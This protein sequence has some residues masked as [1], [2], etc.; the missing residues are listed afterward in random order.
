MCGRFRVARKKEILEEAFDAECGVSDVEWAPG[1]V[2]RYNVAPGQEIAVVRQ[3][4]ARPLR[5]LSPML[6]G[7]I[8]SWADGPAAGYKMI[9]LRSET[10]ATRPAFRELLRS[11]RC[12]IPSDGFYEWKREGK[13][14]L[15]FCFA[16]AG[17]AMFAFAGLWERWK[18]PLGQMVESCTILTTAPNEL[19]QEIHDRMPVMLA[20]GAY[21]LWL[22]P[23]V[24][25]VKDLQPLLKP[26]PA[27]AMRRYRVSQRVNQVKNDD[28]ECATE[29][30]A[31]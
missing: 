18:N 21:D 3:D 19:V 14:K 5:R 8:P 28:P 9:N 4:P 13:E 15:P 12:L 17:D 10:V 2:P 16:L 31:A 27:E 23:G 22:D 30:E 24:T 6:W 1:Y 7:L 29:I 11:R 20:P 26:Y 25:S